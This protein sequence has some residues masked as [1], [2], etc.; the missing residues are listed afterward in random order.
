MCV[1]YVYNQVGEGHRS[2]WVVELTALHLGEDDGPFE[3]LGYRCDDFDDLCLG[4]DLI[5][6]KDLSL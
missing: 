6:V 5:T 1:R 3:L 2:R 4:Q